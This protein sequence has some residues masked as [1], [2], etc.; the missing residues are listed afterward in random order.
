MVY[1]LVVHNKIIVS[2]D[3]WKSIPKMSLFSHGLIEFCKGKRCH[4]GAVRLKKK[5]SITHHATTVSGSFWLAP[6]EQGIVLG[7]LWR[8]EVQTDHFRW[9][10]PSPVGEKQPCLPPWQSWQMYRNYPCTRAHARAHPAKLLQRHGWK[11][12]AQDIRQ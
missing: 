9:E 12:P 3:V 2:S 6:W 1:V 4:S 10:T 7:G 8:K 11:T 5:T